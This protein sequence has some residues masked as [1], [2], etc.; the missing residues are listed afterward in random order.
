MIQAFQIENYIGDVLYLDIRKPEDTGFLVTSVTGLNYPSNQI[1][2]QTYSAYDGSHFGS[3]HIEQ[4]NIV[5]NIV[6]YENNVNHEDVETLRWKL[7]R[8]FLPK[9]QLRFTAI[10]EHGSFWIDGYVET[11][12]INIFSARE[13]A[14]ISILCED[15]CFRTYS[16]DQVVRLGFIE[17]NFEFEFSSEEAP[18]YEREIFSNKKVS[19]NANQYYTTET[20]D[21]PVIKGWVGHQITIIAGTD[22]LAHTETPNSAGGYTFDVALPEDYADTCAIKA[23]KVGWD[24]V[25]NSAG[26]YTIK[27][28]NFNSTIEFG[29]VKKY[30][31]TI[32]DY[33]GSVE[34]GVQLL[35]VIKGQVSNLRINNK[36]SGERIVIDDERI[37]QIM[38][39]S[40]RKN[41]QIIIN[42]NKGRKSA[43]L[44]RDGLS[45]NII[46][47]CLPVNNW[48]QIWPG[49]NEFTY[50]N[51]TEFENAEINIVYSEKYLGI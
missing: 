48:V 36:T 24:K 35:I 50:S 41:D 32:I 2:S 4:R 45:Y 33:A 37:V 25:P 13:A 21:I 38:R 29:F 1:S 19:M 20:T 16:D 9:K 51:G 49:S 17:P 31:S 7:L 3:Q 15:P 12:E 30:P 11:C 8:Y 40:L 14:Q 6:F 26:G 23:Q 34:T 46:N 44:I 18:P 42:T 47:A 39:S 5:M 43:Q 10:N 22:K 27:T 28:I